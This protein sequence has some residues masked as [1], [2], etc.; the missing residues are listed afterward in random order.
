MVSKVGYKQRG[1]L[2]A[3]RERRKPM[4]RLELAACM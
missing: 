3:M 2:A 1:E 4:A